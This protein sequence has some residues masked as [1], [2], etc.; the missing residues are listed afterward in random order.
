MQKQ[1]R[2]ISQNQISICKFGKSFSKKSGISKIAYSRHLGRVP[3]FY[4]PLPKIMVRQLSC[5]WFVFTYSSG[6]RILSPLPF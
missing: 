5:G 4:Q 6:R 3:V 2:I 1:L